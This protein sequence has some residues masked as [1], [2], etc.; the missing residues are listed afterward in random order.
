MLLNVLQNRGGQLATGVDDLF[1][2]LGRDAVRQLHA[3]QVR[4]TVDAR[5]ER[6]V[7]LLVVQ[8]NAVHRIKRAENVF[9][10]TQTESPQEDASQ[11]LALAV[12]THVQHVLLVVFELDP[13]TA[14]GNDLAQEVGAVVGGLEEHAR[15][16]VQ[17]AD[18][19]ALG[20]IDD[21][22]AV[23]SHQRNV[24]EEHLLLL[25]VANGAVSG[26]RILIVD[27]QAH[28]DLERSRVGHTAYFTLGHVILQ[29]QPHRVAALV[30]KIRRVRVVRAA[31][32]TKHISQMKWVGLHRCAAIAA[33]G[34]QVV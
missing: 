4:R 32:G 11:E 22:G 26:V 1:P 9:I 5:I 23:G 2:A 10:R 18:N 6:P 8:G 25:H 27:G 7:Q 28:R 21:E 24:A 30:A 14:I 19:H 16:A 31:L 17:L 12:N 20:A 29:L 3:E 33:R 13:R 15:R 34:T